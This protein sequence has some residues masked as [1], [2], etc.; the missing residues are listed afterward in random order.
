MKA[1]QRRIITAIIA[2]LIVIGSGLV[3]RNCGAKPA[4][5]SIKSG[6]TRS[7]GSVSWSIVSVMKVRAIQPSGANLTAKGWFLI[8]DFYLTNQGKNAIQFNANAITLTDSSGKT[9]SPD[10]AATDAQIKAQGSSTVS[11][12]FN[13]TL[14]P[15]K[16]QRLT[17]A[18][19][20]TETANKLK[21]TIQGNKYGSKQ[22]LI[23]DLGF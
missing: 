12:V 15:G 16:Q 9:Y 8:V 5:I 6:Q 4:P 23:I 13:T 22:D 10:K 2:I 19:D 20:I 11:S 1:S 3:I 21:M 14:N 7:M 17:A 18:F